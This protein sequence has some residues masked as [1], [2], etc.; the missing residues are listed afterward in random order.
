MGDQPFRRKGRCDGH[1][2]LLRERAQLRRGFAQ[3]IESRRDIGVIFMAH[4]GQG[5]ALGKAFKQRNPQLLFQTADMLGHRALRDAQLFRRKTKVQMTASG[6]KS[7]QRIE[8]KV[9][10]IWQ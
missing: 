10:R 3:L 6:I 7:T 1:D 5:H 9:E 2:H 4:L 8:R